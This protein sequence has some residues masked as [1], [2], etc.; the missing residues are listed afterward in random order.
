MLIIAH[1]IRSS[2]EFM[3]RYVPEGPAG[4][5][6]VEEKLGMGLGSDICLELSLSWLGETYY[7]YA[8][9]E[10]T[11]L[12]YDNC[13]RREKGAM[14]R[15]HEQEAELR[16]HLVETARLS[17][18][19]IRTRGHDRMPARLEVSYFG[20]RG[21]ARCG[22]V[23]NLSSSGLFVQTPRPLPTGSEVHLRIAAAEHRVIRHIRGRVARL[24]FSTAVA[25]MGI[26][27]TFTHRKERRAISRMV[28]HVKTS[29]ERQAAPSLCMARA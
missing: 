13:G 8:T 25:G 21:R 10:Q 11:G 1:R 7:A 6:F 17:A 22:E 28:R 15:L 3:D 16:D 9:V 18:E 24:D 5:L 27:F 29:A 20:E 19:Q 14:V 12:V 23:T 2:S 26:E 4:A